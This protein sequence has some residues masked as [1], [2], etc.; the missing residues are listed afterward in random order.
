MKIGWDDL[1]Q[2]K[3]PGEYEFRGRMAVVRKDHLKEWTK[4]PGGQFTATAHD[5]IHG[6]RKWLLGSFDPSTEE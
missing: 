1:G 6:V 5:P 2:P 3:A 4:D